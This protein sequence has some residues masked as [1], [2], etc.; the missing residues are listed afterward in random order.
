MA[1]ECCI[2]LDPSPRFDQYFDLAT[3]V[4]DLLFNL[5]EHVGFRVVVPFLAYIGARKSISGERK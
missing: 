1:K 2:L 3:H 5:L 4:A